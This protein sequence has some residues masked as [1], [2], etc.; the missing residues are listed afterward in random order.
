MRNILTALLVLSLGIISCGKEE[1]A[2]KGM[3]IT[4]AAGRTVMVPENPDRII[5]IGPGSLRMIYYLEA[6]DRVVA[7]EAF[8]NKEFK[9]RMYRYAFTRAENLPVIGPGGPQSINKMPDTEA[10]LKAGVQVIFAAYMQS[11]TANKLQQKIGIPVVV[12]SYG[13]RVGTVTEDFFVSLHVMA[14]ILDKVERG[15]AIERFYKDIRR[16]LEARADAAERAK[17]VKP[18]I[19]VGGVGFRGAQGLTSTDPMYLPLMYLKTNNLAL[20]YSQKDHV[21][22]DKEKLLKENPDIIFIDGLGLN[23]VLKDYAKNKPFYHLLKAY[24]NNMV[25][26]QLP[27]NFYTT[28]LGT[29]LIDTY[30]AGKILYPEQ[31]KDINLQKKGNEIYS[32][33]LRAE[34]YDRVVIDFGD[35]LKPI[36]F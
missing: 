1:S 24:K 7:V 29:A 3:S 2:S 22:I 18:L 34:L 30:A 5:A 10:I 36:K 21:F 31:F 32:F 14:K 17:V 19:Y 13:P 12:V 28:N 27:F 9:G 4:D 35:P 15:R 33:L 23:L 8:E 11:G 6:H 26:M 25:Y 20:K 16:D